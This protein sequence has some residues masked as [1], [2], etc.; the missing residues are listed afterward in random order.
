MHEET[1]SVNI[2]AADSLPYPPGHPPSLSCS[3]HTHKLGKE[4]LLERKVGGLA[5]IFSSPTVTVPAL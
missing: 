4:I 2:A 5:N 1:R 3:R